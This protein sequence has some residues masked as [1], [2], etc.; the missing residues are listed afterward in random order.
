[1]VGAGKTEFHTTWKS[2][3]GIPE[4]G[5]TYF[6]NFLPTS[7][8]IM[9]NNLGISNTEEGNKTKQNTKPLKFAMYIDL[10]I[11]PGSHRDFS[12]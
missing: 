6:H 8:L 11:H 12:E 9:R 7:L 4:G 2:Q 3:E 10:S 1:M 5:M